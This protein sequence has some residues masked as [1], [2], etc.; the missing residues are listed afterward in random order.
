MS[1]RISSAAAAPGLVARYQESYSNL[2][3]VAWSVAAVVLIHNSGRMVSTFLAVYLF[4]ALALSEQWIGIAVTAYGSGSVLGSLAG[5]WLTSRFRPKRIILASLFSLG[6][7]Y[8]CLSLLRDP[9]AFTLLL[10]TG[11][12]FDG[13]LRPAIMLVLM[14]AAEPQDR[15][16][17]YALYQTALNLGYA[18]GAI[19]GG[20]LAEIHFP[21]IFWVN[22]A[23]S[24]LAG[25]V[26]IFVMPP[27]VLMAVRTSE[28]AG[29]A[30]KHL[31]RNW[32]LLTLCCVGFLYYC[33][34][35]QRLSIYPLYLTTDYGLLPSEFGSLLMF[36]GLLT[37][38]G[39]VLITDRLK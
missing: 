9:A 25:F 2:P 12:I 7:G 36:N 1:S 3:K 28:T 29:P 15:P 6:A 13:M 38:A 20:V 5:G 22:G 26:L 17:C 19:A 23:A 24:I 31:G 35:Y 32:P 14:D 11:A 37:V 18:F 16:R 33:V 10:F 30:A 8:L 39:G 4:T 34:S 27:G 21:A